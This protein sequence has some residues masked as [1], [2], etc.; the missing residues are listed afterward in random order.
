MASVEA[1]NSVS[2]NDS[3]SSVS[4]TAEVAAKTANETKQTQATPL[5]SE[6]SRAGTMSK[7]GELGTAG[8]AMKSKLNG[9]DAKPTEAAIPPALS[10]EASVAKTGGQVVIDAG[11][12]DDQIAVTQD[13]KTGA[14][15]VNVNGA[16]SSFTGAD[17]QNLVIKAGDGNDRITVGENVTVK[18]T[19]EGNDGNDRITVDNKVTTGQVIEGGDGNDTL[20]GG[21]GMDYINGSK[22]D[23]FIMGRDGNDV[24]Y[25]GDGDDYV[26][27]GNGDDYLE[28]GKGNDHVRGWAGNDNISGGQGDDKLYGGDGNDVLYAGE[29]KDTVYGQTGD[30]NIYSQAED[31]VE[32]S[33]TGVNNTVVEI[34]MTDAIGSSVVIN[35]TDEFK[36]RIQQDLDMLRSS[37]VGREMLAAW[38]VTGHTVTINEFDQQNG[39][40][41]PTNGIN[42]SFDTANQRPGRTDDAT[43]NINPDFY[44]ADHIPPIVVFY[45]EG[46]HAL[47][48]MSGTLRT[49]IYRGNDTGDHGIKDAERVAVGLPIDH[50]KDP[51]TPEIVAPEH[52]Q[53]LTE[54]ALRD[55]L[56]RQLRPRYRS[57]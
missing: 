1:N 9:F 39:T 41:R 19:L 16:E 3:V 43:F 4:K 48:Y 6:T 46:A 2:K 33:K 47:D 25:A 28:A 27:G 14:V 45:H 24:I 18:L 5:D 13:P 26:S 22:G 49:D 53:N 55:E 40:A 12:G 15:T 32:A 34:D 8:E 38:D 54:N 36:E 23:D 30:N 29:G 52:S 50:D 20:I 37:P 56:N 51:T 31:T 17:S 35:G 57:Y 7:I 10:T 44:P 42:T 11:S 21:G